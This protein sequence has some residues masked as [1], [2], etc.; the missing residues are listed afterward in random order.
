MRYCAIVDSDCT[1]PSRYR[2]LFFLRRVPL[3]TNSSRL[4]SQSWPVARNPEWM[5]W[6]HYGSTACPAIWPLGGCPRIESSRGFRR[7]LPFAARAFFYSSTSDGRGQ[8]RPFRN[9]QQNNNDNRQFSCRFHQPQ[10][11]QLRRDCG[12]SGSRCCR[13]L[14]ESFEKKSRNPPHALLLLSDLLSRYS[15]FAES[16]HFPSINPASPPRFFLSFSLSLFFAGKMALQVPLG[17]RVS[18]RSLFFCSWPIPWGATTECR[19]ASYILDCPCHTC[20][21]CYLLLLSSI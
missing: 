17:L 14:V 6:N 5:R 1:G 18:G 10:H 20:V 13:L 19:L 21:C 3:C 12:L 9:N 15:S 8:L 4:V 16:S 2:R 11:F 7:F